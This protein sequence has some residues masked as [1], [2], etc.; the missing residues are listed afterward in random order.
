MKFGLSMFGYGP[1]SYAR[2]AQAA[3]AGGFE[4]VW[5]S[6]HVVFPEVLAPTYPYTGSGVPPVTSDTPLFDPWILLAAVAQATERIR[7][8][9]N[10]YILPLRHPLITARHVVTLDHLSNGRLTLGIGV[11]WLEG[12]FALL[13]EAFDDRGSRTDEII[14]ILRSL[15]S[16]DVI[17]HRGEHFQLGPLKFQPK[18]RRG[19]IPIEVGGASR[20]ALRRAGRL[21]DGWIEVGSRTLGDVTERLAVV[22]HARREA[23]RDELP[24]EVPVRLGYGDNPPG[25]TPDDVRRLAELGV[26]RVIVGP[27]IE[28]VPRT[29]DAAIE[30]IA[31]FA[32]DVMSQVE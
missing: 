29:A 23:G 32:D 1:R 9:T 26:T 3:E 27:P 15:W 17:D 20:P 5:M 31:R 12:E 2:V 24:F 7:V 19:S 21:G 25:S 30:W 18:P 16:E 13:G 11:G 4:S 28:G 6:E 8:A 22:Q 10:V 14:G